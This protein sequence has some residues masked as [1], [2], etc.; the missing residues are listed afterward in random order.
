M[1]RV[2][3]LAKSLC[4]SMLLEAERREVDSR[5]E[6]L[7]LG[8]NTD[9]SNAIQLHLH[10]GIT[11]RITEIGQMRPPGGIL[12][13]TLYNDSIFVQGFR[14]SQCRLRLLPGVQIVRL[15]A[16]QPIREW[17]PNIYPRLDNN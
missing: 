12:S 17:S 1:R 9:T 16:T 8:Q 4:L 11:V 10:V 5:A 13:V 6:H 2:V 3:Y 14:E 7:R 15:F